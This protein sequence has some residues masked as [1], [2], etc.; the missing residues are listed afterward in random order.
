M[1]RKAEGLVKFTA[2]LFIPDK[3][4]ANL[5]SKE[6]DQGIKL[7]SK[8]AFVMDNCQELLPDYLN[9]VR[10]L[11]DSPD[12][13][14]NISREILQH[15]KNLKVIG[16]NLEKNILKRLKRILTNDKEKYKEFWQEFGKAI[17]SGIHMNYG[18]SRDKLVE[19]LIF[20]SSHSE[21]DLI[22]LNEYVD[23]MD[24]EQD[25]IYYVTG[26]DRATVEKLPQMEALQDRDLEVLYFFDEIDEFVIENLREYDGIEFKSVLRGD[27]KL[28]DKEDKKE[29]ES[30]QELLE[31]IESHLEGKVS[32]V[33]LS[34]RLKSSAVCL[35]SDDSGMS[36]SMEKILK[37]MDQSLG[38]AK[39]ILEINPDHSLF[40]TLEGLY[41]QDPES[42]QLKEYS[43]L[44][45]SLA[46]LVEGFTPEDP[47]EFTDKITK[48][49]AKIG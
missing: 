33:R 1:H 31:I 45:Y 38:Q 39:R 19:L 40:T 41:E 44:L 7:Y 14:L 30:N 5:Y 27:L 2:L 15:S 34:K 3:A 22:T 18:K 26:R 9:F 11:V 21:G 28:D 47:V 35:I 46:S 6:F 24:E 13:S 43:E 37:E 16:K 10:G 12:F 23:R 8:N 49:M 29:N 32:D 42:D 20:P 36:M 17:K 25:V 48:L 4:P